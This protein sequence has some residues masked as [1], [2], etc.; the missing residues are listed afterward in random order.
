MGYWSFTHF[1]NFGNQRVAHTLSHLLSLQR[2]QGAGGMCI[3]ALGHWFKAVLK[4]GYPF[5]FVAGKQ[6]AEPRY[7]H[8]LKK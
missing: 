1:T 7:N 6:A 5:I 2:G 8:Q 3:I 4:D